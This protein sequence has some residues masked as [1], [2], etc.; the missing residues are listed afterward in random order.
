MNST[1]MCQQLNTITLC[2]TV[3]LCAA[4]SVL[5]LMSSLTLFSRK[6]YTETSSLLLSVNQVCIPRQKKSTFVDCSFNQP[7]EAMWGA[8]EAKQA[9]H[10]G[11][12]TCISDTFVRA[13][14]RLKLPF[15]QHHGYVPRR[16]VLPSL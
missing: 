5:R 2:H 11:I 1:F 14:K 13:C 15:E 9:L 10:K 12:V 6:F 4:A 7:S 3:L 8:A 16:L